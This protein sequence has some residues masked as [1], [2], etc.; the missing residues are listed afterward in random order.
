MDDYPE[1]DNEMYFSTERIDVTGVS[2]S[3]L[4]NS[5]LLMVVLVA[6]GEEVASV[7]MVR[8]STTGLALLIRNSYPIQSYYYH[9]PPSLLQS[10]LSPLLPV[11]IRQ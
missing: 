11:V 10:L 8:Y 6:E 1:G 5:G 9:L 7:N 4:A 3:T 2:P